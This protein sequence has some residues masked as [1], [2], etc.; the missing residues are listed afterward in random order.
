MK[1][2]IRKTV[3]TALRD[4]LKEFHFEEDRR[5]K[6]KGT[7]DLS[8]LTESE[9]RELATI[10]EQ[11][12]AYGSGV[13]AADVRKYLKAYDEGVD[14]V[15]A[16]K[17]RQGAWLMEHLIAQLDHHLIFS[18]DQYEGGS[19]TGYFVNDVNYKKERKRTQ[20]QDYRP[21]Q[22][23]VELVWIDQD[24]RK[25]KNLVLTEEDVIGKTASQ[26]LKDRGYVLETPELVEK[27]RE[28]TE[29]YYEIV[30]RVG[31]QFWATGIAITDI[32]DASTDGSKRRRRWSSSTK[33]VRM[34]KNQDRTRVVIDVL[35]ET[36]KA[37]KKHRKKSRRGSRVKLYR[38]H[39]QNLRFFTP[40]EEE[41]VRWLEADEDTFPRP[42]LEVPV[43][44]L[45]PVFDLDNH[46]RCRV[47]VNN[48]EVYEYDEDVTEGLVL[49]D[50]DLAMVDT[51]LEHSGAQ[52]RDVVKGKGSSMNVLAEGPPGTGKTLTAEVFAEAK[53]RPLYP[54]DCA[55]LGIDP[56]TV[57]QNLGVVLRRA[58]RWNAV[59]LLDEA[60]VYIRK[61]G[62]DI[63]HNAIVGVFLRLLERADCI[64]WLTTN[65]PD[66]VDDAIASRCVARLRYDAPG[67]KDQGRIWHVLADLN[68]LSFEDG[69]VEALTSKYPDLTGRDVK[70]LLKL[71]SIIADNG[72]ITTKVVEQAMEFKPTA[73][74][75]DS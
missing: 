9:C 52:F 42:E 48:L 51:L 28:E 24:V 21:A 73:R 20:R 5:R 8:T 30:D 43:H 53:E 6:K 75:E 50:R 7:I 37:K 54:V 1:L 72:T 74:G 31:E 19:H 11:S 33:R 3:K 13:L 14:E 18:R 36:D 41:Q 65:L 4:E 59:L 64:L 38:W 67:P 22:V 10:L 57:E 26:M 69:T 15:S 55:E 32:D 70:N 61:R 25:S 47:H 49:P 23:V 71:G 45:V 68:G 2:K 16:R 29:R 58:N 17:M 66:Q 46:R 12:D 44:P 35:H 40:S 34:D 27:M 56:D 63:R 39:K 60:D 62:T